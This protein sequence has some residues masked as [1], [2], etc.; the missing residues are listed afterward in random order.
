MR[1]PVGYI[2]IT[3]PFNKKKHRGIDLGWNRN[4]GGK[5]QPIYAIDDGKVIYR[6]KQT[7]GGNVL[8]I[9]HSNGYVS[10]YAH[11]D[12]WLVKKGEKVKRG[13]QIG[14]MGATGKV[15]G[16]HLHFGLYK[17]TKINY[18]DPSKWVNPITYLVRTEDQV[19]GKT[20]ANKYN[21][22]NA[23]Y[24]TKTV[25]A[26]PT[27]NVRKGPGLIYKKVGSL[28]YKSKVKVYETSGSW[29]RLDYVADEWVSSKYIK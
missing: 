27:L 21:I 28:K 1:Y 16:N 12:T 26:Q 5:N 4:Y 10:E 17:G 6:Q 7:S 15:S 14:T 3:V 2:A 25:I 13:Q 20:T 24:T 29:S 8:H 9:K 18:N 22:R 23:K 19:V 11:L